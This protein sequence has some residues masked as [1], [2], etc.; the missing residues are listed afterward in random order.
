LL[1]NVQVLRQE[2]R[3]RR[4]L[5]RSPLVL[6][7]DEHVLIQH[8]GVVPAEVLRHA[9]RL[10]AAPALLVVPVRGEAVRERVDHPV[11]LRAVERPPEPGVVERVERRHRVPEPPHGVH[12]GHGPVRHG[13]EL[14][15]PA[16]LEPRRHQQDVRARRDAVR[17]GH[18]EPHPR[19]HLV[20]VLRLEPPQHV[21][22]VG[23]PGAQH[24]ELHVLPRDPVDRV[25]DDVHALLVVQPPDEPDQWHVVADLQAQLPLQG[26]LALPLAG[27]QR[28]ERVVG[29]VVGVEVHVHSGVP[30][31][32]V[33]AVHDALQLPVV[34]VYDVV[35]APPAFRSLQLPHVAIAN[36]HH[37][38]CRL[39]PRSKNVAVIPTNVVIQFEVVD[40][41]FRQVKID[42]VVYR[43]TTLQ[44]SEKC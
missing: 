2:R 39:Q 8:G 44:K 29:V 26:G 42:E 27:V 35:E 30:L 24:H 9:A 17:Q 28:L 43:A 1:N 18:R 25:G 31:A 14:V 10:Q 32:H 5:I 4:Q 22:Q 19:A 33:D 37:P 36:G 11:R 41:V 15:Q 21:L 6:R 3:R 23:P 34:L 40:V 12:H 38:V 13:V 16:R 7:L 20:A